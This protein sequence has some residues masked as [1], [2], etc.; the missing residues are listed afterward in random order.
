MSSGGKGDKPR[1]ISV[2][3]QEYV[4]RWDAIFGK[5]KS[6]EEL[7]KEALSNCGVEILPNMYGPV[8][9]LDDGTIMM[10]ITRA[11]PR[12]ENIVDCMRNDATHVGYKRFSF[13]QINERR[14]ISPDDSGELFD[15]KVIRFAYD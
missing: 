5:K 3:P 9:E 2:S 6:D 13:Y 10:A 12:Y 1:P 11:I 8:M 14:S 7:I 4:D 15:Q